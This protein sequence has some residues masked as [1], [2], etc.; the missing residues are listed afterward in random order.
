LSQRD[1]LIR[2]LSEYGKSKGHDI[3]VVFDGW[4]SGGATEESLVAGG[5]RVV[6]SRLGEKADSVIKRIVCTDRK[7]WI[8]ISSDRE[9]VLR[10]W[11]CGSV[12]VS[13][14]KFRSLLEHSGE[15]VRGEFEP[16]D[17]DSETLPRK[18][19]AR[20]PSRREKTLLRVLKKL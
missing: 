20:T 1:N 14:E 2:Q 18:G 15:I 3:T 5:I 13:S 17:D 12:P 16:L 10:A 9:I 6:Y 19:R 11:S 7:E 4:K 8:V